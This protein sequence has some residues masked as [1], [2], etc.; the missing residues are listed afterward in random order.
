MVNLRYISQLTNRFSVFAWSGVRICLGN[1]ARPIGLCLPQKVS[2]E[3]LHHREC[4][5]SK[6]ELT[7]RI[8]M[9]MFLSRKWQRIR[10][11]LFAFLLGQD[12]DLKSLRII[13]YRSITLTTVMTSIGLHFDWIVV[14]ENH[15]ASCVRFICD[16]TAI[17]QNDCLLLQQTQAFCFVCFLK[18]CCR[19]CDCF[20][21]RLLQIH[22]NCTTYLLNVDWCSKQHQSSSVLLVYCRLFL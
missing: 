12:K 7:S 5:Q 6:S 8:F 21:C 9:L 4:L 14:S 22:L 2:T 19:C 1:S 16:V 20:V 11:K 17:P 18:T 3:H 15:W 13:C 10:Q